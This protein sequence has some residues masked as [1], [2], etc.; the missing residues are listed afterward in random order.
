MNAIVDMTLEG[1]I[2]KDCGEFI[3]GEA[4][5]Y[6]RNCGCIS[7]CELNEKNPKSYKNNVVK[8]IINIIKKND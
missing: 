2:C 1:I 4:P 3:D 6:E 8:N 7:E 5:G